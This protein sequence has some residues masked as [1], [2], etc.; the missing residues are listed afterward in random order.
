MPLR[1]YA[2]PKISPSKKAFE[3][4]KPRGLFSEFYGTYFTY[5]E[6][7]PR[8]KNKAWNFDFSRLSVECFTANDHSLWH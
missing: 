7:F 3:N 5:L 2:P 4:F 1:I 8:L 6:F